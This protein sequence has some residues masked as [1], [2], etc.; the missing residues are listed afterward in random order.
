MN[1]SKTE[2]LVMKSSRTQIPEIEIRVG[3]EVH[4]SSTKVRNLGVMFDSNM[5]M[6]AHVNHICKV[7]YFQLRKIRHLQ[8]VLCRDALI[9]L[10]HA[11]VTARLD[12]CNSVLAGLSEASLHKLQLI[13]NQAARLV[14][15]KACQ[16][17]I[18]PVLKELHWLPVRYH[19][20][21]KV[22][23][24]CFKALHGLAP[25]YISDM[26]SRHEPLRSLRSSDA[27]LLSVPRI[28]LKSYGERTFRYTAPSLWNNLPAD[29]RYL[30]SLEIFKT[31]I[32]TVLFKWAYHV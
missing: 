9:K 18:T 20:Q 2:M 17:H 3:S 23:V 19:I 24:L 13:Q 26:L 4:R 1:D 16:E 10:V 27:N 21:F 29:I 7:S 25:S 31:R 11:F 30:S 6:D 28:R 32:K 5:S 14:S 8:S 22:L 15:K 12:Y